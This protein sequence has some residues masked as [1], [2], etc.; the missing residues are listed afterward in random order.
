MTKEQKEAIIQTLKDN[1]ELATKD[2]YCENAEFYFLYNDIDDENYPEAIKLINKSFFA[3]LSNPLIME[4]VMEVAAD[5]IIKQGEDNGASVGYEVTY[6]L[7]HL[8]HRIGA[9]HFRNAINLRNGLQ[10]NLKDGDY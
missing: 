8:A 3:M 4:M 6:V 10:Q 9:Y 2:S 5:S 7:T 1:T